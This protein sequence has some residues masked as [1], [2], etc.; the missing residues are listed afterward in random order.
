MMNMKGFGRKWSWPNFMMINM[1]G[2][3]RKWSWP[4]FMMMNMSEFDRKWSWPNLKVLSRHSPGG[5][6][7]KHKTTI[8]IAG[9]RGRDLNP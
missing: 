9:R 7:E 8:S 4:N 5:T 2:F 1:K 6:E 3:G